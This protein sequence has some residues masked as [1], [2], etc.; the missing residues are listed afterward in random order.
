MDVAV[1][2]SPIGQPMDQ[3]GIGVE[4]EDDRLVLGKEGVEIE[5]A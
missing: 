5:I 1:V 2:S 4:G 3:P